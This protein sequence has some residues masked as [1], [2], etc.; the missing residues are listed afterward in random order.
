MLKE[1]FDTLVPRTGGLSRRTLVQGALGSG[2]AASVLPVRAQTVVKTDSAGLTAG[3]VTIP[4]GDFKM[5]AYRAAP[6]GRGARGAGRVVARLCGAAVAAVGDRQTPPWAE[7]DAEHAGLASFDVD[8]YM[9]HTVEFHSPR[10][11][12]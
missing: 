5:P 7:I 6:A 1:E 9:A 4:V 2:F 10:I 3:E 8:S 12:T 11:V